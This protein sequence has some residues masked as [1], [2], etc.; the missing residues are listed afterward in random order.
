MPINIPREKPENK[1]ILTNDGRSD[2]IRSLSDGRTLKQLF[3]NKINIDMRDMG[4]ME[5]KKV[6]A[7]NQ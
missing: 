7:W 5:N 2:G 6:T 1:I 4:D 3:T